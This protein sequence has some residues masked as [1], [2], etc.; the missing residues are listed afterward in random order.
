VPLLRAVGGDIVCS[1]PVANSLVV[2]K[3]FL[4]CYLSKLSRVV[5]ILRS[6]A[7]HGEPATAAS[8]FNVPRQGFAT[9]GLRF[10]CGLAVLCKPRTLF[11]LWLVVGGG[12]L[13][14]GIAMSHAQ[15]YSFTTLAG[16]PGATG[17]NDGIYQ[18]VRFDFPAGIAVDAAGSVYVADFLNHAI[19]K[20][21]A[22]GTNWAVGTIAGLAGTAGYADGT[23]SDARFNRPTGIAVDT[24][25]DLFVSERYNHTVRQIRAV[26][27]DWVVSTV[28][29]LALVAGHDDGTNSDAR[30][31]LPSGIAVDRS[32]H[33]YVADTSNFTIREIVQAGTNWVVSTIAGSVTNYGFMDGT[34]TDALFDFPYDVAVSSAG[35]LYVADWGNNAIR[36]LSRFGA[37]WVVETIAGW[38]GSSGANDGTGAGATFNSPAGV[39]VDSVGNV[40]VAD[41]GNSTI[42]KI[43][44]GQT[45]W[46]VS[47]LAGQALKTGST[48]GLG[49]NALFKKAW[50][51]AVETTGALLVTDYGNSTVRG[52]VVLA[53]AAPVLQISLSGSQV[54]LTWPVSAS[55][56]VLETASGLGLGASWVPSTNGVVTVGLQFVLTNSLDAATAFYRLQ[57]TGL[58]AP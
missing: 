38:S 50:G 17:T 39:A 5:K 43:I 33:L 11:P 16:V 58:S 44:P 42:R 4:H 8:R 37:D 47:T 3:G 53:S 27:T 25:G 40:Y 55:D 46:M 22:S 20:M 10:N 23:N 13:G 52:G 14:A 49:T 31:Y 51:I 6:A 28:A 54:V 36:E 29:G 12:A 32:N 9:A 45:N 30:F 15:A 2:M 24:A 48:D 21:T 34:N 57:K 1:S 26:G 19:R 41:Q 56:Y 35:K 18:A 7:V